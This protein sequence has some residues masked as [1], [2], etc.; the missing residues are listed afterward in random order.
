M[1][2]T[3]NAASGGGEFTTSAPAVVPVLA[4]YQVEPEFYAMP[5][6]GQTENYSGLRRGALYALWHDGEIQTISVRRKGRSRG[7]RLIVGDSLRSY[8]RKLREEQNPNKSRE[9]GQ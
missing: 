8:L 4:H 5:G 2:I 3:N 1:H 9:T 6:P 7:R